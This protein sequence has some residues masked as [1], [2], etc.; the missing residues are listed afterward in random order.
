M[1]RETTTGCCTADM[2][3]TTKKASS[4]WS[5]IVLILRRGSVLREN[6]FLSH[7]IDENAKDCTSFRI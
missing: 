3:T 2:G 4:R 1:R 6:M 7:N 5:T